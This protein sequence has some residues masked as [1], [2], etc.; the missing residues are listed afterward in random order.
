M[1]VSSV[2]CNEPVES[3][4]EHP[5]NYVWASSDESIATVDENGVVTG[6]ADGVC[7]ITATLAENPNYKE[8]VSITVSEESTL[9]WARTPPLALSAYETVVLEVT[10][11]D[12]EWIFSGADESTYRVSGTG[13][14]RVVTCWSGSVEPLR[15]TVR[16]NDEE[17]YAVMPL[18]G[19]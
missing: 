7:E 2:R 4:D 3:T 14:S 12:A 1:S 17:I 11:E 9:A 15:V 13:K 16:N 6:I 19:I 8:S 18:N 5:I 10:D